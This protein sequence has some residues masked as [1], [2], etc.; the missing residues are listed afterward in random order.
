[1]VLTQWIVPGKHA[2][3]HD[4]APCAAVQRPTHKLRAHAN[5]EKKGTSSAAARQK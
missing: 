5:A 1:V 2:R 4:V 3:V